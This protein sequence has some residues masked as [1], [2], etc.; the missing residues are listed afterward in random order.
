MSTFKEAVEHVLK[1]DEHYAFRYFKEDCIL[2]VSE[3][4]YILVYVYDPSGPY[5]IIKPHGKP[6]DITAED[7]IA[8]DWRLGTCK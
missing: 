4:G 7:T 6:Q 3:E 8:S 1:D 2:T 5:G